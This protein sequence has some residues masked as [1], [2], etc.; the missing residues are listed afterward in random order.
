MATAKLSA[1][2]LQLVRRAALIPLL[3][4]L[5]VF[6]ATKSYLHYAAVS[7][8][9]EAATT[10]PDSVQFRFDDI[11]SHFNGEVE[12]KGATLLLEGMS[13]PIQFQSLRLMASGW[14]QLPTMAQT[15][16]DGLLPSSIKLDFRVSEA[17]LA[18]LTTARVLPANLALLLGCY[19]A[20]PPQLNAAAGP[21]SWFSGSFAY[22]FNPTS[23][24][25]NTQLKLSGADRYQLELTADLDVGA[26]QLALAQLGPSSV[27]LGGAEL[28]FFNLGAQTALLSQ[29]G[30][31]GR[32]GLIEGSY[33]ARQSRVVKHSLLQQ[34]WV[35]STELELA[36]QDYLFLPIR[37][38]LQLSS[39]QAVHL[40]ALQH[41]ADGWG[42]FAVSLGL[43]QSEAKRHRLYWQSAADQLA[44]A[45]VAASQAKASV[46][47]VI[48]PAK[49][50]LDDLEKQ[51]EL[52]KKPSYQPSYQPVTIRQLPSLFGAPMKVTKRNGRRLEGVLD[53]LQSEQLQLRLERV[54]G[55]AVV[56]VRL[57]T[58]KEM[59]AY[60]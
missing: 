39:P 51:R 35:A 48:E 15:L 56:P 13:L 29:C 17:E 19:Q 43:N 26:S 7:L 57:E 21:V 23:E 18:R 11:D 44:V 37:L 9:E 31:T 46:A 33:V 16:D 8:I 2:L 34:G 4:P 50:P 22:R 40:S 24:Y 6:A 49:A 25:L 12:I 38:D 14:R 27:G 28:R 45:A 60:F 54:H 1:A 58:I 42:R 5:L 36:Y 41:T 53:A 20:P 32:S 3:L 52:D 10:L 47:A 30:A 55:F 59:Q